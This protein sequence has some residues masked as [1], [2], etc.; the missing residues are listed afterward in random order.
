[1]ATATTHDVA[2]VGAGAAGIAAARRLRAAGRQV[3]L[4]EASARLGGRA[5]TSSSDLGVAFDRGCAWLHSADRN[6]MRAH[7]D[8]L[9]YRYGGD[10]VMRYHIDGRWLDVA[11][12]SDVD[13][14]WYA[15]LEA[16]ADASRA[17]RPGPASRHLD[18][19]ARYAP[20]TR[21]L[22]TAINGVAPEHY[23]PAEAAA[24][25]DSHADWIVWDGLGALIAELGRELPILHG[26]PVER[27]TRTRDRVDLQTQRGPIRARS[28]IV[29]AS[30]GVLTSGSIAFEPPLSPA[31]REALARLTM[32][33]AEK[34]ALRFDRDV[35]GLP[36][37]TYVTIQRG[38]DA[39]GFHVYGGEHA[40]A[41][42][43]V[44]GDRAEWV[45]RARHDDIVAWSLDWLAHAFG[46]EVRRCV[47]ATT[48]TS[49]LDDA[50]FGGSYSAAIPGGHAARA[51][52][53]R[54]EG[55][56]LFFAGEATEA[57]RFASVHGAWRSGE[58]AADE[59]LAVLDR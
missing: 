18:A 34:V 59:A 51:E 30:L 56:R 16:I 42:G 28:V 5:L 49:W 54:P 50:L 2:I 46:D 48:R 53:A 47:F 44:G 27:I 43:Y 22:L 11:A 20:L 37:N 12:C 15:S 33:R 6:P 14:H 32:G 23:D 55:E 26:C 9:A 1:M 10:P 39:M 25:D 3:V 36:P 41:V 24:E 7:A 29:T 8:A 21:Y 35:F 19:G 40:L 31:K 4:L 45:A 52:L 58:H 57:T 17:G 38:D 13:A